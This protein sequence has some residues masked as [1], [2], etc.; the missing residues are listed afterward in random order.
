[1]N[2]NEPGVPPDLIEAA[3]S[4]AEALG[5]TDVTEAIVEREGARIRI[6]R[7]A[8]ALAGEPAS[9]PERLDVAEP[10]GA[11]VVRAPLAGTFFRAPSPHA[12]PYVREGDSVEPGSVVG[13]IE[14]MKVFNEIT[15]DTS[16]RVLRIAV[17]STA[18]VEAG[19]A[20]LYVDPTPA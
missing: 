14:A 19:D 9:G 17:D 6:R 16:G 1:V 2:A 8:P 11:Y 18:H 10:G 4:L 3:R 12:D 20:L 13:L 15:A 5:S 7:S